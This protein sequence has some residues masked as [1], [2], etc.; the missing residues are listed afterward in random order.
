MSNISIQ[1]LHTFLGHN[2]S[3]YALCVID[4]KRFLSAGGDGMVVLW[5]LANPN[6][7][8]VVAKVGGSV[9]SIAYEPQTGSIY[10][11]HNNQGIHKIDLKTKKE[12]ASIQLGNHQIYDIEL[13]DDSIW[14]G[15]QSGEIVVL[16]PTLEVL[17]RQKLTTDRIRNI[18]RFDDQLAIASSDHTIRVKEFRSNKEFN[19]LRGHKNSVFAAKYHPSGKY[20]ASAGRDAHLCIWDTNE[21]Y[22]LRE[23][24]A[25]HL[26]TINDLVFS[27]DGRYFVTASMDKTI[28]LWDAYNFKLLK[29]L[30]KHRHAGHGNSVNKL[31]WMDYQ[32]LL[33]SCSDDRS[34]SIWKIDFEE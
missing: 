29:V 34:I 24:I 22:L 11:G 20:L 32:D 21:N 4:E 13:V 2:D 33:V 31:I 19:L 7:G 10:I 1:K 30:D 6:E 27:R 26:F 14:I 16:S 23:S 25:A 17:Q 12:L 8:E 15:L 5:D 28:K 3:I 9:Y 18:S